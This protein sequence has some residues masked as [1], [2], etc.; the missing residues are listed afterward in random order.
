[1]LLIQA[2]KSAVMTAHK[3]DDPLSQWTHKLR[4]NSGWQKAAVPLANKNA[5][6]LRAVMT[7]GKPFYARHVSVKPIRV[8]TVSATA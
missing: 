7:R 1:M 3:R 2:A 8:T 5:R 6:I 4:E